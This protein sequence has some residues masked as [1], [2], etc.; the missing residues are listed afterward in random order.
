[1]G[2]V[3][4]ENTAMNSGGVFL[5]SCR[6]V[7]ANNVIADNGGAGI[8]LYREANSASIINNTVIHNSL[9][10]IHSIWA[11]MTVIVNNIVAFN[12]VGMDGG[13][14]NM[15]PSPRYNCVFGNT[16]NYNNISP[17]TS[18]I[19][20]DPKL[21][22]YHIGDGSPCIDRGDDGAIQVD[23]TDID[24]QPRKRGSHV[25]IGADEF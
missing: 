21:S 25:D 14:G 19:S 18:D 10:G 13:D 9:H 24:G 1:M 2:N 22:G 12:S 11:H 15:L 5:T 3:I 4:S 16:T 20:E 8:E 7:L 17:G 6:G 23:W